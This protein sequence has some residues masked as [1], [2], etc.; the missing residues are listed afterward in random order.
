MDYKDIELLQQFVSEQGKILP[1]R[2]T[3]LQ[4]KEQRAMAKA[5]K[6]ARI[7]GLLYFSPNFRRGDSN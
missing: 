6:Q 5:I 3:G 4:A 1:R 7:M 2:V